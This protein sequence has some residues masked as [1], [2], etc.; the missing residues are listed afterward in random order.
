MPPTEQLGPRTSVVVL[1]SF[2][3]LLANADAGLVVLA[4]PDI[5]HGLGMTLAG[6]HWVT[7]LYVLLIGGLQLLGGR[8]CDRAG[9]RR[10]LLLSLAGFAVASAFCAAAP[11]GP[12]LLLARAGQAVA[13]AVMVPAAM[14]IL[15]TSVADGPERRRALALW[16]ASGGIGSVAGVLG[17]GLAVSQLGWRWAFLLNVPVAL[18][19]LVAARRLCPADQ[20]T[21]ARG[22]APDVQGALFLVGSLLALVYALVGT[23][24]RGLGPVTWAVFAVS[25]LL[26]ALFLRRQARAAEPLL[27]AVLLRN[28][29]LGAGAL[30]IVFVAAATGPVVFLG[31][32]YLQEVHGY[33]A[34]AAGCALLPV[35]GGVIVVGRICSRLLGRLGPRVPCLTGCALSGSGLLLLTQVSPSSSYA[36]G[37]LPGLALVGAGLP[38]LWMACEI[39][40]VSGVSRCAVGAAAGVVQCAGQIGAAVGLALA[41]SAYGAAGHGSGGPADPAL[42]TT[43]LSRA[44]WVC[45]A[46][47]ACAALT[48]RFGLRPVRRE[49]VAESAGYAPSSTGVAPDQSAVPVR[50]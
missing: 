34:W 4:L 16:A 50:G 49:A 6:A 29:S 2:A 39:A 1:L 5:Q 15:L 31:S 19:A 36:T 10:L 40:A 32:V 28:R 41:V 14:C 45:A 21:R 25:G 20:A 30:G 48:A 46:L 27:P 37:L 47:M 26:A 23:S 35:V 17:G 18:A 38:F 12:V 44:F 24:E 42:L 33:A 13:A 43:G 8:L 3:P 9:S 22:S 11:N 7:N